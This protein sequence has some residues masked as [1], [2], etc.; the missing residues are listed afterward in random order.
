M[1]ATRL[2]KLVLLLQSR[3]S[4]TAAEP[5]AEADGRVRVVL[6]VESEE[7]AFSQLLTLGP[8]AEILSPPALRARFTTAAAAL[9]T[10]YA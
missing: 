9:A 3:P 10:L 2:I 5:A 1:R 8:E 6:R 7:V 4:M